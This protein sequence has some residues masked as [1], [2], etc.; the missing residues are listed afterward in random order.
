MTI[1]ITGA[2]IVGTLAARKLVDMGERPIL[3]EIAPQMANIASYVDIKRVRLIRG[4]I[5]DL[6]DL[7]RAIKSEGVDRIIHTA[8]F[9]TTAV[10]ER[11][12]AGAKTNLLGTMNILEAARLM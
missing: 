11:P 12:Y 8:S 3:Y 4:D 6:P 7:L 2:G 5:L 9:L 1:L 10:R